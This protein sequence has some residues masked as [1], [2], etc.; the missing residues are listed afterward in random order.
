MQWVGALGAATLMV[1]CGGGSD[2][3]SSLYSGA[4]DGGGSSGGGGTGTTASYGVTVDVQRV[5]ASVTQIS[6]AETV[7]VVATVTSKSG[8]PVQGVVVTFAETGAS[9]LAF[10]PQSAT[11]LTDANGRASI[12]LK[13]ADPLQTGATTVG[14]SA[15]VAGTSIE[16]TKSIQIT[17]GST[18]G[19]TVAAPATM[20]FVGSNPSGTAIVIRGTGGSGRSESAILTFRVVDASNAPVTAATVSFQLNSSSGGATI[21][22]TSAVSNSDGTVTT[23]V[24]SGTTPASI[25]VTATTAGAGG[26]TISG[27]SDTLIVSNS[28]VVAGGFEIVAEKYN[29]NGHLTGDS[30]QIT[31][32]VRDA[33]GNPVPDGLAVNF[34][35]D[36]GAV[37]SS[38]LGGCT[39]V[40]GKCT[41]D[42]RV[43]DPRGSGIATVVGEVRVGDTTTLAATLQI[44]MAGATGTSYMAISSLG[45]SPITLLA[46]PQNSCKQAFELLLSDGNGHAPAAGTTIAAP[47][48][49]SDVT[50]TVKTGTPVLD[51]LVT[52]FPPVEFGIEVDLS[53]TTLNPICKTVAGTVPSGEDAFFRLEF[54]TPSG[55]IFSQRIGLSYSK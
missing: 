5:G 34:T 50:V 13:A 32:Y 20:N 16:S 25:V 30:T 29:L 15:N 52:G 54:K 6:S 22:P 19:G 48:A 14:V 37:A 24:S 53:S 17:A 33:F 26:V 44:N 47:F 39:T 8:S 21:S 2:G 10:L 45:G 18:G 1:A 23:T 49:S 38:T 9:L 55:Q 43:Q 7:Q 4:T 36:Y 27:Q 3:G 12:D 46:L 31:A 41:V 35:T 42:F 51:Q 40:N 28:V 11:A